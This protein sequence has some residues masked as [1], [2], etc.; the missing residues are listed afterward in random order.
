MGHRATENSE[1]ASVRVPEKSIAEWGVALLLFVAPCLYLRLFYDYTILN[2]DEGIVL[3]GAQRILQGQVLYRDFFS[4]YTPGSYYWMALLFKIFGSSI[5]VARAALIVYGGLF[6]VLT[7]LLARR[8]CSRWSALLASYMVTLSCLPF[9]FVALH[10]WDS[11]LLAYLTLYCA[12]LWLEQGHWAWALGTGSLAA[13]TL[14]FEHSKGAGLMLGLL[15]GYGVIILRGDGRR[16]FGPRQAAGLTAGFAW[17]FVVTFG[18]F[19][20]NHALLEML[21]DWVWPLFHYAGANRLRYGY[22]VMS[23]A[24]RAAMFG[25]SWGSRLITLVIVEPFILLPILPILA[26]GIFFWA[27]LR[28]SQGDLLGSRWRYWVLVS[29]TLSGLLF[30]TF[31]TKRPDF[32]HLN[33]LGPL[34][35][36][37]VAWV[38]DGL[39][40][41]SR[42]W[43]SVMPVLVLL[44]FFS[45]TAFGMT[46]LWGP[47]GAHHKVRTARGTVTTGG[48]DTALEDVQAHVTPGEKL[49]VYP[50]EPLYYYL[51]G[52]FNPTRFDFLQPGM[53]TAEQVQEAIGELAAD[54]TRVV[55]FELNFSEQ[56]WLAWPNTPLEAIATTDPFAD[57]LFA[58]YRSCSVIGAKGFWHFAFMVRKEDGCN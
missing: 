10:N 14:L 19:A 31:L 13:L 18:Y 40:L 49:F 47:L 58:H 44:I 9:R 28:R 42:P 8:V 17:P 15:V 26:L 35:Y 11:T 51:T 34:F 45:Y 29:A 27:G 57:Y 55:L 46:L 1:S 22:L 12:V 30:S 54:R 33:Y 16:L 6:S 36:L 23:T 50:Y 41:Q 2:A 48:S 4:F 3:Q 24:N 38:L 25:G 20:A 21:T 7:Y 5:L 32:T 37:V 52:T 43:R 39:N 53:H 56:M